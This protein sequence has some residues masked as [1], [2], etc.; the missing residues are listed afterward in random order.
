MLQGKQNQDM[1]N[2]K[3]LNV[4]P[5]THKFYLNDGIQG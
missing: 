2:P 4:H 3:N 1:V 5:R